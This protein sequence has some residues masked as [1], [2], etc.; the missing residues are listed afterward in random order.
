MFFIH[1]GI[2]KIGSVPKSKELSDPSEAGELEDGI[3]E[4][5]IM[6]RMPSRRARKV[7]LPSGHVS[8]DPGRIDR[9]YSSVQLSSLR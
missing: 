9:N 3:E 7:S 8:M 1:L 2:S 4:L 5:P 6:S